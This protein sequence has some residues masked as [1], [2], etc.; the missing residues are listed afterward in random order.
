MHTSKIF[1][2]LWTFFGNVILKLDVLIEV[3]D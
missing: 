2:E 3:V 1:R